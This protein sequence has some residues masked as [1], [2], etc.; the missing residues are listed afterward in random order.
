VKQQLILTSGAIVLLLSLLFFGKIDS[1]K[2]DFPHADNQIATSFSITDS[3]QKVRARLT[4]SQLVYV[5]NLE[6]SIKRGD[7]KQQSH[8][9]FIH[10]ANFWKD[11]VKAF[12]PYA[13]YLSEAAKLD[14]SEKSLTFAAQLI[15]DSM[16][17]EGNDAIKAWEAETAAVLEMQL[18]Q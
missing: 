10:L 1:Q 8:N 15:L 11:S 12:L 5:T 6:N 14:K 2:S 17:R 9:N 3:I 7:V 16:R 4:A 18:K 13:Y